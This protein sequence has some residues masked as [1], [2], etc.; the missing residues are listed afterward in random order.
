[1]IAR[2]SDAY[3]VFAAGVKLPGGGVEARAE[4]GQDAQWSINVGTIIT[5]DSYKQK[6]D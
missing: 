2:E 1:M 3:L 6:R 4:E 5:A